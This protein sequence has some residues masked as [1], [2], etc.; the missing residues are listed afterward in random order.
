[1]VPVRHRFPSKTILRAQTVTKPGGIKRTTTTV[2]MVFAAGAA[3]VLAGGANAGAVVEKSGEPTRA[4]LV[5]L[6]EGA[7]QAWKSKDSKFWESFLSEKFVGWGSSGRLNKRSAA[8]EYTGA[9][10]DIESYVI[11][12]VQTTPLGRNAALITHKIT[13]EGGCAGQKMPHGSWAA[14]V[15]NRAGNQWQAVFHAEAL[16]VDPSAPAVKPLGEKAGSEQQKV[17][18]HR[19][20]LT[21]ALLQ[22]E[23]SIGEGWAAWKD[24]DAGRLDGLTAQQMQFINIFGVHLSTKA[25]ALKNWSGE[26]CDVKT[27]TLGDASATMISPTLG[28]LTFQSIADGTCF[29]QKVGP[30]WG[31]SIYLKDGDTWKWNFGINLPAKLGGD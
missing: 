15:Y 13:V 27:V 19:D 9:D 5:S 24:H 22:R 7:Y 18:A 4:T 3:S 6:E 21:D 8:K 1:M 16:I 12:D 2:V 30:V 23:E 26:G 25:E 20:A 14:T 29:G 28:I 10:C 31:S 17:S 11:S